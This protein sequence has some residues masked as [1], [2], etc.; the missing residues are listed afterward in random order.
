MRGTSDEQVWPARKWGKDVQLAD[1]GLDDAYSTELAAR[2]AF[3]RHP[4]AQLAFE[5]TARD[6]GSDAWT[7]NCNWFGPTINPGLQLRV[8]DTGVR[9]TEVAL[10]GASTRD[11]LDASSTSTTIAAARICLTTSEELALQSSQVAFCLLR[12]SST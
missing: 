9:P 2:E 12:Q 4:R 8:P 11:A 1:L 5:F 6:F 7:R 3:N 10:C